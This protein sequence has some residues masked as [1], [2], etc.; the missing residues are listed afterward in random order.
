MREPIRKALAEHF[1]A[2]WPGGI[3]PVVYD[4]QP[5][6]EEGEA[7]GRFFIVT[8]ENEPAAIGANFTRLRGF[9]GLQIWIP[10]NKGTAKA[11][12]ATD[13]LETA[14]QFRR[15]GFTEGNKSADLQIE[16]GADGPTPKGTKDGWVQFHA[17]VAFRCDITT[18]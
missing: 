5:M 6:N 10:E 14:F 8:G 4:N 17:T 18:A 11:N 12:Q 3:F 1:K 16:N 9:L 13:A 15:F 7:W 2:N